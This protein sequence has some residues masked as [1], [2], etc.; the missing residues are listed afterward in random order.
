MFIMWFTLNVFHT[1]NADIHFWPKFDWLK[2]REAK[3]S[4]HK[5]NERKIKSLKWK[6][7][8][9]NKFCFFTFKWA[10]DV[11]LN[12]KH[13][14]LVFQLECYTQGHGLISWK[15][16]TFRRKGWDWGVLWYKSINSSFICLVQNLALCEGLI[17]CLSKVQNKETSQQVN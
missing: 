7:H 3:R 14:C 11:C 8:F 5:Q 10:W 9:I 6:M 12:H 4:Q 16:V 15:S 1:F 17:S 13:S 2:T